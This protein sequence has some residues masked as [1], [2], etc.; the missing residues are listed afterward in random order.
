MKNYQANNENLSSKYWKSD[1]NQIFKKKNKQRE[2]ITKQMVKNY[3]TNK[4]AGEGRAEIQMS[5][6][7]AENPNRAHVPWN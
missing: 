1:D 3:Q 2:Q 7:A 4:E 6:S 5:L